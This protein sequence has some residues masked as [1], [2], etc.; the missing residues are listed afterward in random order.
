MIGVRRDRLE[1]I[2]GRVPNLIGLEHHCRFA[3]RCKAREELGLT[4]CWEA[5]PALVE[6]E[7]GH[8]VRCFI[9]SDA[10]EPEYEAPVAV[11]RKKVKSHA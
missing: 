9:H 6:V 4:R 2:P 1:V 5:M 7:P 10:D 8:M 3:P 11:L